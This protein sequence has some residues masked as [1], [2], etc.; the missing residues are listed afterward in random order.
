M[1]NLATDPSA[2]IFLDSK[3]NRRDN[4]LINGDMRIDQRNA[5][6]AV[7][8]AAGVFTYTLDRWGVR[9]DTG[10]PHSVQQSTSVPSAQ[11]FTN[12]LQITIG[13]AAA[14]AAGDLNYLSQ[15]IEGYVLSK[16]GWGAVESLTLGLGFWAYAS[17]AGSYGVAFVNG[18]SDYSY[19]T[20]FTVAETNKWVF[21]PLWIP[22]PIAGTWPTDH[23]L[24]LQV[25]FDLGSGSNFDGTL[26]TWQSANKRRASG[27]V[28]LVN[29]AAAVLRIT[30][31]QLLPD[32]VDST[33]PFRDYSEEVQRA[34]RYFEQ[35]LVGV[36]ALP[37]YY[38]LY[39]VRK[40]ATPAITGGGA[41]FATG[42]VLNADAALIG[43]TAAAA[44]TLLIDAE[45]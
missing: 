20:D 45:L 31:V 4:L 43:Q 41:G 8:P 42:G 27:H 2:R 22:G 29:N 7:A 35:K 11:G 14:P 9:V 38:P 40:R 44:Q 5:G 23:T 1:N 32:T 16:L 3:Y 36:P 39:Y 26:N 19:V 37:A 28:K 34:L 25:I 21:Y 13:A 24:A 15:R 30:G 17:V 18:A 12:S 33:F 6:G 10:G